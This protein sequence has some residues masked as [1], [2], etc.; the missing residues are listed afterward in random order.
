MN[1][2]LNTAQRFC[3][4]LFDALEAAL[5]DTKAVLQRV[6]DTVGHAPSFAESRFCKG[7]VLPVVD[8]AATMFLRTEFALRPEEIHDALRCEG[9]STLSS[10]YEPGPDQSGF[11][12]ATWGQNFQPVTKKGKPA[13]SPRGYQPGPDF[14]IVC[15]SS[16]NFAMLGETKFDPRRSKSG[17]LLREIVHDLKYYVSL[18]C[19]PE[20]G[21]DYDFGFGIVYAA[22]GEGLRLPTLVTDHW[23]EHRFMVACFQA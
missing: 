17:P 22:G 2:D 3:G 16:A 21:W 11:G 1:T 12:G 13:P 15:G 20:K 19:E 8:R 5:G 18:P 10:I 23:S 6:T 14:G 9:R 7:C 4:L